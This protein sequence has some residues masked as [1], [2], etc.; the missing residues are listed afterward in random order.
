MVITF[1]YDDHM[2]KMHGSKVTSNFIIWSRDNVPLKLKKKILKKSGSDVF[3][4]GNLTLSKV[5]YDDYGSKSICL[6][7]YFTIGNLTIKLTGYKKEH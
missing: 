7:G 6:N 2:L 4:N 1:L 5:L 3:L